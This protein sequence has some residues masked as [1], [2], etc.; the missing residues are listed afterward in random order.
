[1]TFDANGE[2]KKESISLIMTLIDTYA[3]NL[4]KQAAPKPEVQGK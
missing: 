3:P 1:M 2:F 4:A